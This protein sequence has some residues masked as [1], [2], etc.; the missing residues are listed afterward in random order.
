MSELE[1]V[2]QEDDV[3]TVDELAIRY[4]VSTKTIRNLIAEFELEPAIKQVST[5]GR[6]KLGY[7][8]GLFGNSFSKKSDLKHLN[9]L[10]NELQQA[11]Y[12]GLLV[13]ELNKTPMGRAKLELGFAGAR[14]AAGDITQEQFNAKIEADPMFLQICAD[15]TRLLQEN[16]QLQ[17]ES[18]RV[19]ETNTQVINSYIGAL[20]QI[21]ERQR[22]QEQ[23]DYLKRR[24]ADSWMRRI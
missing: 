16:K 22:T 14:L 3:L 24:Q 8:A 20:L 9:A 11:A 18:S 23:N 15:N 21:P 7:D 5:G 17:L 4:D 19:R 2:K 6:P 12:T 13:K 10:S 1:L